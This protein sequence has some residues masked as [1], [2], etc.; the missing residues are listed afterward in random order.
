[1]S[2]WTE[3]ELE[4]ERVKV[5]AEGRYVEV[6]PGELPPACRSC[7]ASMYSHHKYLATWAHTD[8]L[9]H[10]RCG[11]KSLHDD[12]SAVIAATAIAEG[13]PPLGAGRL[14][15]FWAEAAVLEHGRRFPAP[16]LERMS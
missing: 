16:P 6:R 15:E 5:R 1:M 11:C 13:V 7:G 2:G 14:A 9:C 3:E 4:A 8:P 10:W 12:V